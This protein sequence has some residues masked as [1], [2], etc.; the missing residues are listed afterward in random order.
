[1]TKETPEAGGSSTTVQYR[2]NTT[3]LQSDLDHFS[4]VG[5]KAGHLRAGSDYKGSLVY[6]FRVISSHSYPGATNVRK[7][8]TRHFADKA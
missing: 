4:N 7:G 1:M 3:V 2:G 8:M 6:K 5:T